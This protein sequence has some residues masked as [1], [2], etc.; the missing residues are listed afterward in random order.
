MMQDD[1]DKEQEL[2][3]NYGAGNGQLDHEYDVEDNH[4]KALDEAD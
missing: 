3:P 1:S 4:R 2:G